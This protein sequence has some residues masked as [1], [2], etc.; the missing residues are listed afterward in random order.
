MAPRS[1]LGLFGLALAVVSASALSASAVAP[2]HRPAETNISQDI[3]TDN[4]EPSVA[5]DPHDPR[6]IIV[7]YLQNNGAG[8]HAAMYRQVPT[9]QHLQSTLQDCRYAV[10]HDGGRSWKR[11]QIPYATSSEQAVLNNCSDETVLFDHR[12]TAYM[13]VSAF[14]QPGFVA[15]TEVRLLISHDAG[16]TWSRPSVA[17]RNVLGPTGSTVPRG[18]IALFLDRPWLAVDESTGTLFVSA[19]QYWADAN[20]VFHNLIVVTH[21]IDKGRT[22]SHPVVVDDSVPIGATETQYPPPTAANG[23][24]AVAY[25]APSGPRQPAKCACIELAVSSDQGRT[26]TH[27]VTPFTGQPATGVGIATQVVADPR[28]RGVFVVMTVVGHELKMYRTTD[29]GRT[30]SRAVSINAG[31]QDAS[32]WE[33][34]LVT[35]PTGHFAAA[36]RALYPDGTYE[37]WAAISSDG[38]RTFGSPN[39][40]STKRSP[41]PNFYLQIGGDDTTTAWLTRDHLLASWGDWRGGHG[42]QVL[43]ARYKL[44]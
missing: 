2:D 11:R 5:A 16:E 18:G 15:V 9:V 36:W 44:G 10:T 32:P 22:W 3:S 31:G 1:R 13:T 17:L 7:G 39:R 12:G 42:E 29:S 6:N 23:L 4:G 40:L 14:N 38:G 35:S 24:L 26:F 25:V 43:L 37:A 34:W 33:P 20:G 21:S 28:Q 30:W 27:R 19:V 41:K 8:M